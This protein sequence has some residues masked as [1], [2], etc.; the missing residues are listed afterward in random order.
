MTVWR[1]GSKLVPSADDVILVRQYESQIVVVPD[2]E[3]DLTTGLLILPRK[4][5]IIPRGNLDPV[6]TDNLNKL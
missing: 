4:K 6:H 3:L 1:E 5:L 2:V